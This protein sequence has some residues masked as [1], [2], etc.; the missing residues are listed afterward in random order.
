M[1]LRVIGRDCCVL[2][3]EVLEDHLK[4]KVLKLSTELSE[5]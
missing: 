3:R 5:M 2:E 4:K 1:T